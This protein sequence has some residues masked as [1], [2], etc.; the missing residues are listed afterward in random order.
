[1]QSRIV[2]TS[3]KEGMRAMNAN[4]TF[5]G[6]DIESVASYYHIPEDQIIN[7]GANVN[8]LGLSD[9]VRSKL[10]QNIDLISSYPDR[11]YTRLRNT[12]S[13]YCLVPPEYVVVGNGASELISL[14][15]SQI[16]PNNTLLL[17]PTYSEY[18]RELSLIDSTLTYYYLKSEN[19]FM[20]DLEEFLNHLSESIDLLILCNPNNPTSSALSVKDL[21]VILDVCQKYGIFVM[22]DETYVEFTSNIAHY[23][24]MSL[25]ASYQNL[26]VLRGVS[27][28]FSAP[29]IRFGYGVSSNIQFIDQMKNLQNPWS[30]NSLGAFAGELMLT[31]TP[32]IAKTKQLIETERHRIYQELQCW[33]Y[34]KAYK[35]LAN[36]ILIKIQRS[37]LTSFQVF[38]HA[39]QQGFMIR[40]CSSFQNLHGE[41]FRFCIMLPEEN[42]RL[43]SVLKV[44][45]NSD[46]IS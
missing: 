42:N 23:T 2:E 45:I 1:M 37:S 15:I 38:E 36:F 7:F 40:D 24:G 31:D 34:V 33:K 20:L 12:I 8:P 13:N 9:T 28:F 46:S 6:S 3:R 4:L 25:I 26:M 44:F 10:I 19:N 11:N 35:P 17:G 14:I 43:L 41:F 16:A 32:Y 22:I 5:H 21:K 39:I 27:K 29:G 30:L 18:E